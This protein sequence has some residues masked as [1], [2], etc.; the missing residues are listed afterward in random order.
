MPLLQ[1]FVIV[2]VTSN[3]FQPVAQIRQ[4]LTVVREEQE[5]LRVFQIFSTHNN[6]FKIKH[7]YISNIVSKNKS[8]IVFAVSPT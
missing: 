2:G 8:S 3:Q 4:P 5:R 1:L 7:V 6:Y